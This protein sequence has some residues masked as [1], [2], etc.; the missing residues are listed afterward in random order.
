MA[1]E[2]AAESIVS[3]SDKGSS[4]GSASCSG[5]GT[6]RRRNRGSKKKKQQQSQKQQQQ[7]PPNQQSVPLQTRKEEQQVSSSQD[8]GITNLQPQERNIIYL[9]IRNKLAEQAELLAEVAPFRQPHAA[10]RI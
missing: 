1:N 10:N 8:N 7:Q 2:K 9:T 6:R 5:G 4:A 3:K